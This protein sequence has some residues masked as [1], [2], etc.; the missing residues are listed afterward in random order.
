LIQANVVI[1]TDWAFVTVYGEPESFGEALAELGWV[2][3]MDIEMKGILKNKT[4]ELV[5]RKE[6]KNQTIVKC[7]WIYKVKKNGLKKSQLVAKG[8]LKFTGLVITKYSYRLLN[9]HQCKFSLHKR[10]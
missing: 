4:W 9:V 5:S 6:I 10:T 3:S 8:F 2:S 1:V 7:Y